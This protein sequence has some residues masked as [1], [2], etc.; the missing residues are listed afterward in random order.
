MCVH[1]FVRTQVG[2]EVVDLS[3][4]AFRAAQQGNGWTWGNVPEAADG[5]EQLQQRRRLHGVLPLCITAGSGRNPTEVE[6]KN[7]R[8]L[9]ILAMGLDEAC[10]HAVRSTGR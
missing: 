4:S 3:Y 1:C 7:C 8:V 6:G 10:D 9:L 2:G 5:E